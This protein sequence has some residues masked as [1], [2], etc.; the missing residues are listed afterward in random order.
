LDQM[1]IM[2]L[3]DKLWP[4][5]RSILGN[6]NRETLSLIENYVGKDLDYLKFE[7]G[8]KVYDWTIPDEWHVDN[9][10]VIDPYGKKILDFKKNNLHLMGYSI[11]VNS[12]M[13]LEELNLHLYSLPDQP[14]A[15]PYVTSYYH[16]NWGFC[17]SHDQRKNLPE[18]VYRVVIESSF[19]SGHLEIAEYLI[20]GKSQKEIF[21]STYICHPSMANN[22]MSGPLV[23]ANI[24][25]TLVEN[26]TNCELNYSVR[27]A[28]MPETIGSISYIKANL[29]RMKKNVI[30]GFVV[31]C[32]G[33]QRKWSF[34]PTRVGNTVADR[35]AIRVLQNL[36]LMFDQYSWLDR[37]SDERQYCSPG[38]DLPIAS[39]MRSKYGT[40]PE[41]HTSNDKFGSV[42]TEEGICESVNFYLKLLEEIQ[43]YSFPSSTYK[44]EPNLGSRSLYPL[45]SIKVNYDNSKNLLNVLSHCDGKTEEIEIA[46]LTKLNIA[47]VKS[48]LDILKKNQLIYFERVEN[49]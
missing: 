18:G 3:A 44:C 45:V 17:L 31:T 47:Q 37:G 10:Y 30:C 20:K 29:E 4:L 26:F 36:S 42:V 25:K 21:L 35:S 9:A 22:E 24:A 23:C 34:L 32:V 41:Y 12:V 8:T 15:I 5:N 14:D 38:V 48:A 40:F 16:K 2:E 6:G 27:I 39:V 19:T 11:A 13:K 33:D 28:F 43:Q 46:R 1:T 49:E 7:S